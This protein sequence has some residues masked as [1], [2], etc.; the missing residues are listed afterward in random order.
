MAPLLVVALVG[1]RMQ[2]GPSATELPQPVEVEPKP[3]PAPTA[4]NAFCE[5]TESPS[6]V[7]GST[8]DALPFTITFTEVPTEQKLPRLQANATAVTADGRVLFVG[9]RYV[10]GLHGFTLVDDP[11]AKPEAQP[12]DE[13]LPATC[14]DVQGS[15]NFSNPNCYAWL[16]D[17][18][19][20]T[21][22]WIDLRPLRESHPDLYYPLTATNQNDVQST[23]GGTS[24][25]LLAGGYGTD[26][27]NEEWKGAYQSM[28]T[29]DTLLALDVEKVAAA[30]DAGEHA[31]ALVPAIQRTADPGFVS[32]GGALVEIE[33]TYSLIGGMQFD[34]NYF[35]FDDDGRVSQTYT[36]TIRQFSLSFDPLAVQGQ[37]TALDSVTGGTEEPLHRRDGNFT[38]TLDEGGRQQLALFGGVF[39][40]GKIAA[41]DHPILGTVG[42]QS[43]TLQQLDFTQH[44]GQYEA[45]TV[46]AF[47]GSTSYATF[48]GGISGGF[49][50]ENAYQNTGRCRVTQGKTGLPGD[51]DRNDGF[52]FGS[53]ISTLACTGSAC[54]EWVSPTPLAAPLYPPPAPPSQ[55]GLPPDAAACETYD[56]A[57]VQKG[58]AL[59]GASGHWIPLPEADLMV[60]GTDIVDLQKLASHGSGA[61]VGY[62]FG[63]IQATLPLPRIPNRGTFG[64]NALYVVEMSPTPSAAIP[65]AE[66][67]PAAGGCNVDDRDA[68]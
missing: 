5:T 63:G 43:T 64:S 19:S 48:M 41:Y 27:N 3:A 32:T 66:V 49:V 57:Q 25:L 67:H 11:D 42:R 38:V 17:P 46:V 31:S 54:K 52:P 14:A 7:P 39:K 16:V 34:G 15:S 21:V 36:E 24:R 23:A 1:C 40:P 2:P 68:G 30:I 60:D 56:Y 13:G 10:A 33:G 12:S 8:P 62:V 53:D 29:F 50:H 47:D 4:P 22:K 59:R 28:G 45:P 51:V 58:P 26:P 44:L 65:G 6:V 61:R 35:A 18:K 9:G 55:E 20:S 37:I